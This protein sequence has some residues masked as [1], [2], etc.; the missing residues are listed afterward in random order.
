MQVASTQ[1]LVVIRVNDDGFFGFCYT[2]SEDS[3]YSIYQ[4]CVYCL[5]TKP[6]SF[7]GSG[8]G[9]AFKSPVFNDPVLFINGVDSLTQYAS[10]AMAMAYY[11]FDIRPYFSQ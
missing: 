8:M 2:P 3:Q 1:A 11:K 4:G 6:S 9:I 10:N 7:T 5:F